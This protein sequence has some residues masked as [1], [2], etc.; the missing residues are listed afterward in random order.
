MGSAWVVA[1]WKKIAFFSLCFSLLCEGVSVLPRTLRPTSRLS[2][3][4]WGFLLLGG[5]RKN[6][7]WWYRKVCVHLQRKL[8]PKTS[9]MKLRGFAGKGAG[10]VGETVW[11]VFRGEQVVR[12]MPKSVLNPKTARQQLSRA[13]FKEAV[14]MSRIFNDALLVGYSGVKA[15]TLSAR[16]E[17]VKWIIPTSAG[18]I[19][20]TT[21]SELQTDVSL[22]QFS[23]GNLPSPRLGQ[24]RATTALQV[25]I[26]N[27]GM[28]DI[29]S[30]YGPG[31]Y[32]VVVVVF[33]PDLGRS[34]AVQVKPTGTT[35]LNIAV[36]SDWSGMDVHVY[37]FGKVIPDAKNGIPSA[38]EPWMY[39][40]EASAT[41]FLG[42]VSII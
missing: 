19:S 3:H 36:P 42:S 30:Q 7:F 20:G 23:R 13:K 24:P 21:P 5:L 8:T 37:A 14:T 39:P 16:N 27:D 17:F 33:Q 2:A 4:V 32:G 26:P 18:V 11:S 6:F 35:A 9:T 34:V 38:T 15:Q 22:L 10:K 1:C 41:M 25:D 29:P 31:T 40:S 12:W 28:P